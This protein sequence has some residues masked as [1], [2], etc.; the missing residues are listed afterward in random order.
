Y[1]GMD[2]EYDDSIRKVEKCEQSC[3]NFLEEEKRKWKT[4]AISLFGKGNARYLLEFSESV[5]T[6]LG[7][8]YSFKSQ[9]K[10]FKR[11][12][13]PELTA[14]TKALFEAEH[15]RNLI[16]ADIGRRVF[17][18]F[19]DRRNKW[20]LVILQM[21]TIDAL[22]SFAIYATN[23]ADIVDICQPEFDFESH[24][25]VLEIRRGNHPLLIGDGVKLAK[26]SKDR[27]FVANDTCFGE[28]DDSTKHPMMILLT[29][30][31]AGGKSTIMR[32]T[33]SLIC[34]AQLGCHVPAKYMKLTP[35]DRIFSRIG[36][37][38][39]TFAG[40]STFYVELDETK[41]IIKNA[42]KDSFVIIDE[43][44]RGTS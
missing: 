23:T 39:S 1:N 44:G 42:T 26:G 9:R 12:E 21:A 43:L 19:A 27:K 7:H 8:E 38:D 4:T 20:N 5:A 31:N 34:M 24:E 37:H 29:G 35:A 36:A 28:L 16:T 2:K 11:Y 6:K 13:H 41:S 10:G 18:D 30:P 40:Q 25:P 33:A 3:R 15:Q 22:C 32:Q 14:L 17:E